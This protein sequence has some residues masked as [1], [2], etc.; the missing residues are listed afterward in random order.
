MST[1]LYTY[2]S[3]YCILNPHSDPLKTHNA[4]PNLV[5]I[6]L[7]GIEE[8]QTCSNQNRFYRNGE[9]YCWKRKFIMLL[10]SKKV[11]I[12]MI[13]F[14]MVNIEVYFYALLFSQFEYVKAGEM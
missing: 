7:L 14:F 10:L 3:S 5:F 2:F 8:V 12:V 9:K 4:G 13:Y 6:L 1:L 11:E